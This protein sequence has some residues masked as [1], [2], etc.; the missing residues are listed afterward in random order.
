MP[1]QQPQQQQPILQQQQ[2][3]QPEQQPVQVVPQQQQQIQQHPVQIVP[4]EQQHHPVEQV[5]PQQQ[6]VQQEVPQKQAEQV[7]PGVQQIITQQPAVPQQPVL[8]QNVEPQ[9]ILQNIDLNIQQQQELPQQQQ[10]PQQQPLVV[11]GDVAAQVPQL[12]V[13]NKKLDDSLPAAGVIVNRQEQQQQNIGQNPDEEQILKKDINQH[14]VNLG[15]VR[16]DKKFI[17]EPNEVIN[18]ANQVGGQIIRQPGVVG[19]SQQM[20]VNNQGMQPQESVKIIQKETVK[21]EHIQ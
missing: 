2:P 19:G 10:L 17:I 9:Q 3:Q 14:L 13:Q 21:Q 16:A 4:Q 15:G 18:N 8:Q 6:A 11:Q 1:Q 5:I 7:Q 12:P 20:N